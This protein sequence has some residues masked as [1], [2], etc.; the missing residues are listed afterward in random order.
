[1]P[2]S[3]KFYGRTIIA[4]KPK[5]KHYIHNKIDLNDIIAPNKLQDS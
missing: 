3:R 5:G 1:M 2:L 4:T